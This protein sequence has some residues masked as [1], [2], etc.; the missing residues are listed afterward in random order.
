MLR[1]L[2][3]SSTPSVSTMPTVS[4]RPTKVPS[5]VPTGFLFL[6]ARP[7]EHPSVTSL[8]SISP[9]QSLAP[10]PEASKEDRLRVWDQF[11][12]SIFGV[13]DGDRSGHSISL[14]KEGNCL[15]IGSPNSSLSENRAGN[16][17]VYGKTSDGQWDQ[18][19]DILTGFISNARFGTSV[20][21]SDSCQ[22]LAVGA[23]LQSNSS[24]VRTGSV[25]IYRFVAI[26][27][28]SGVWEQKGQSLFGLNFNDQTGQGVSLSSDGNRVV[29]S[30]PFAEDSQ[31]GLTNNGRVQV[32]EFVEDAN[33]FAPV[34][35]ALHGSASH[36]F[37][38]FGAALSSMGD[39]VVI[40]SKGADA[41]TFANNGRVQAFRYTEGEWK[42][43][44]QTIDGKEQDDQFGYSVSLSSDGLTM[45]VGSPFYDDDGNSVDTGLVQV[46]RFFNDT[47]VQLGENIIGYNSNALSGW[48]I[49]MSSNGEVLAIG[50]QSNNGIDT[51][52]DTGHVRVFEFV[53]DQWS[54]LGDN[55][56]GD[57]PSDLFGYDV[58]LSGDGKML[59]IGGPN[60]GGSG[61]VKTFEV[62]EVHYPSAAPS[63]VPSNIPSISASPTLRPSMQPS[64]SLMPS[65]KPSAVPSS[66]P[67]RS[68]SGQPSMVPSDQVRF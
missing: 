12:Q 14:S 60:G 51:G 57:G 36:D 61:V 50:S 29:V 6:S 31:N 58:S 18:R 28:N 40:S 59:A 20:D 17:L 66:A 3:P 13:R 39:I 45:A 41:L 10:S 16:V 47:W 22:T 27:E 49:A 1:S 8:P 53:N 9:S 35:E 43:L 19:G 30:S 2:S 67:S 38:G 52:R 44:G 63:N 65:S 24:G 26:D 7:S 32:Y 48:S 33:K 68:P 15:A 4:Q 11:A 56:K 42:Q 23:I 46:F 54:Q 64:R 34:G 37:F 21:L 55:F 25:Q 62:V 5:A